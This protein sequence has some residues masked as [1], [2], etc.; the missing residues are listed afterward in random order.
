MPRDLVPLTAP[1]AW[2]RI[3]QPFRE[4]TAALDAESK[5]VDAEEAAAVARLKTVSAKSLAFTT[6]DEG[7][8]AELMTRVD[9]KR[10]EFLRLVIDPR[11][12]HGADSTLVRW[13]ITEADGAHCA[14]DLTRDVTTDLLAS[15]PH[16]DTQG[17]DGVWWFLD[18]SDGPRLLNESV[19]AAEGREGLHVWR[20]GDTPS[21]FVNASDAPIAVWTTLP[22]R[23]VFAH[24]GPNGPVMLG[25]RSPLTGTVDVAA[26]VADAHPGGPNGVAVTLERISTESDADW[27]TLALNA[28]KRA[29]I[30]KRR[31]ELKTRAPQQEL[32]FAVVEATPHDARILLRG[33]PEKPGATVPRRWLEVFGGTRL[34]SRRGQRPARVGGM[35]HESAQSINS[36]GDG[37]SRLAISFRSRTRQN[38]E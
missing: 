36:T 7:K 33:E 10:G 6:I 2:E 26:H 4:Q 35:A 30:A 12:N 21:V 5:R 9:V 34:P 23:S 37:Q 11:G 16:A 17:H 25:W 28:S 14:W 38:T 8:S 18:A 20:R 29:E 15:N 31:A 1:A 24:P 13:T 3:N 22:P 32:A 27:S 19:R